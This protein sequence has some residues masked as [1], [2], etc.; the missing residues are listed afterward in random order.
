MDVDTAEHD[1]LPAQAG[2]VVIGSGFGGAV[3]ACRRAEDGEHVVVLERGRRY[4]PHDFPRTIGQFARA[5]WDDRT[6]DG[7]L[8]YRPFRRVDVITGV[9]VGGGSLHYFNVNVPA[10]A[11]VFDRPGW[12]ASL[13][14][15]VLD[16]YYDRAR[17]MLGSAELAVPAGRPDLPARTRVFE[18]AAR[19]AGHR[20][21]PVTIAVHTGR[22]RPHPI[23]GRL[24]EPCN[25]CGNCL[26]GCDRGS[27]N[28]LDH[29][30][31]ARAEQLG[32]RVVP[33]ATATAITPAGPGRY[34][35]DVAL[36]AG[37]GGPTRWRS[38]LCREVVVSAGSLGS[39]ELLLRCRDEHRTLPDLSPTLGHRFSINGELLLAYAADADQSVDPGLGPPITRMVQ[40]SR[41]GH[42]VSV[43][44]LGLPDQLLWFLDGMAPPTRVRLRRL[45]A[46]AVDYGRSSLGVPGRRSRVGLHL[47]AIAGGA[48]TPTAIPFLGM[49]TDYGHGQLSLRRGALRV[50]W[51][52]RRDRA[53][54]REIEGLMADISRHAGGRFVPSPLRRWPLRKSLT[55]HPLGGCP[56]GTDATTGVVDDR[57]RVFGYPGLSVIDGSI[58]PGALAVNPSL[59]IAALAERAAFLRVEGRELTLADLEPADLNR[60]DHTTRSAP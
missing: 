33:G 5:F 41:G 20:P 28:T 45:A 47:E 26:L 27:K 52:P 32:A 54:Y 42:H 55:A 36:R 4:G 7:F 46:T 51:Q 1:L 13:S 24:Q 39:T 53:L 34:R 25:Y 11:D 35:V 23:S 10:P 58:I 6:G 31:L 56:I 12:P 21:E 30:Y 37:P 3:S 19:A 40:T 15:A 9:G 17:R 60:A 38:I 57:G 44:D 18:A 22:A 50:G 48:R 43:Q 29:N 14:R 49:G 2:V 59:T 16:P 8:E